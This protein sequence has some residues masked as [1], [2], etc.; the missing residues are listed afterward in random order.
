MMKLENIIMTTPTNIQGQLDLKQYLEEKRKQINLEIEAILEKEGDHPLREAYAYSMEQGKRFRPIL[1]MA[2]AEAC[3]I[4]SAKVMPA[5]IGMEMIHNFSLVHDDLPCMDNDVERR[6]RPTCHVKFG[7]AE[8]LLAGDGLLIFAFDMV[9]RNSMIEGIDP[10]NVL[11]VSKLF[12]EAAGHKGMTGGQVLDVRYQNRNE[13]TREVLEKIHNSKTGA[14]IKASVMAGGILAGADEKKIKNLENYGVKIGL[15]YQVVDDLL[16]M[17]DDTETIS[18]PAVFG[19][20][21]SR[22]MAEEATA[23]AVESLREFDVKADPL[24]QLA[25]YLLNRK[26]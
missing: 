3:G 4:D 19:V 9:S 18:F 20:E 5:A 23:Q 12:A 13:V 25:F 8:A 24:R 15:T 17:D 7:E 26:Y 11:R 16:D 21:E 10:V 22:R 1:V 6:G 2:A 14:L